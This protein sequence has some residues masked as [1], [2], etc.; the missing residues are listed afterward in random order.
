VRAGS[1][2]WNARSFRPLELLSHVAV[3]TF[4]AN[5]LGESLR[6][7][8]TRCHVMDPGFLIWDFRDLISGYLS[9]RIET[10]GGRLAPLPSMLAIAGISVA[11]WTAIA[12]LV[13]RFI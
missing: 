13:S 11:L 10:D 4:G 9:R 2:Y 6:R 5:K 8:E 7:L 1:G 12:V 3:G